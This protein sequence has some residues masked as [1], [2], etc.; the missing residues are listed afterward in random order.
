MFYLKYMQKIK[1][2]IKKIFSGN[3]FWLIVFLI[4]TAILVEGMY[5]FVL[6]DNIEKNALEY[7]QESIKFNEKL[8]N[9]FFEKK[10]SRD[11]E[12]SKELII[13]TPN[14]FFPIVEQAST[15]TEGDMP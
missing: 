5:F 1:D 3:L 12:F 4:I 15:T 7:K 9:E 13:R 2:F 14:P 6:S 8:L 10:E 11:L